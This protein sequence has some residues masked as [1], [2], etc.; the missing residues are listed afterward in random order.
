M[1]PELLSGIPTYG[2]MVVLAAI[3]GIVSVRR[4][5]ALF[6]LDAEAVTD[7]ALLVVPL[8]FVLSRSVD[9]ALGWRHYLTSWSGVMEAL[10][11]WNG[12]FT[13]L[14]GF[15]SALMVMWL[16][17]SRVRLAVLMDAAAPSLA[18]GHAV[19]RL[20]CL[21]AGCCWGRRWDHGI[22]LSRQSMAYRYFQTTGDA[23]PWMEGWGPVHPTQIYESLG[24]IL[25]AL[26][27]LALVRRKRFSGHLAALYMV[28][29]GML[30][31]MVEMFRGDPQRGYVVKVYTPN[32]AHAL[33]F[34]RYTP[35]F[36]STSQ[37]ISVALVVIG[38]IWISK[39]SFIS[40]GYV[41][42]AGSNPD[43]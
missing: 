25:I 17:R 23:H 16:Y 40:S 31:F 20:G 2:V 12:G 41:S 8:A 5:S 34:G 33:G 29:Y 3:T 26:A 10:A 38:L 42:L 36:L 22:V 43:N 13:Y 24:N 32:L 11:F 15:G 6:G 28:M 27:L 4:L 21:F 30:R 14:G 37:A 35:V 7:M 1:H 9:V 39:S 18:M 19:G